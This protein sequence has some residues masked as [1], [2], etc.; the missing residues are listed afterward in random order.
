M[1][2]RLASG[3]LTPEP[4]IS[5]LAAL[6]PREPMTMPLMPLMPGEKEIQTPLFSL[7]TP[8]RQ[9]RWAGL[10]WPLESAATVGCDVLR[11]DDPAERRPIGLTKPNLE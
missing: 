7:L 5:A 11:V 2:L 10:M 4:S 9:R 6:C 3:S 8:H 1:I